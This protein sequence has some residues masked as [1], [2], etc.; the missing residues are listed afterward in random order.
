MV[1]PLT[2]RRLLVLTRKSDYEIFVASSAAQGIARNGVTTGIGFL[3]DRRAPGSERIFLDQLASFRPS[4]TLAVNARRKAL[5]LPADVRH[6]C[7]VHDVYWARPEDGAAPGESFWMWDASWAD[8]Y[9]GAFLPPAT[10]FD[11]YAAVPAGHDADVSFVGTIPPEEVR[12]PGAPQRERILKDLSAASVR[13]LE[14]NPRIVFSTD[15]ARSLLAKALRETGLSIDEP[16]RQEMLFHIHGRLF[17]I[18]SRKRLVRWLVRICADRGWRFRLA[19]WGWNAHPEFAPFYQ[20]IV[21]PGEPLARFY[22]AHRVNI[23]T[24]GTTNVHP[25]LLECL[26]C[27]GFVLS[28]AHPTDGRPGGLRTFFGPEAAPTF[29]GESDLERQLVRYLADD[30]VRTR[31]IE[32]G[33]RL[34]A[35]HT[36]AARMRG[37]LEKAGI[38]PS[39]G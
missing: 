19:G 5:P 9:G 6:H 11:A 23:H 1:P 24:E 28:E 27:G 38:L 31:A 8:R 33:K 16:M 34:A 29:S 20:G 22:Q 25:R 18:V 2:D 36:Y 3:P 4:D 37:F 32:Q 14:D 13:E 10:D 21:K 17:R 39:P 26:A 35:A 12:F 7:W 30:A 15:Y